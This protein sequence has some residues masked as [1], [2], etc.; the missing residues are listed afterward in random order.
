MK[1]ATVTSRDVENFMH[2]VEDGKTAKREKTGKA[3][4]LSNVRGGRGAA[5]RTV[6]LLGGIFTYAKKHNLCTENPV[7]SVDRPQMANTSVV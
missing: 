2:Q 4:G 6:G 7:H 3:R 5:S 1:V